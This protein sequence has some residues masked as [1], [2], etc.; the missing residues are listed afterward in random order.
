MGQCGEIFDLLFFHQKAES[1]TC[2][3]DKPFKHFLLFQLYFQGDIRDLKK[4]SSCSG[5]SLFN[6]AKRR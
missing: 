2:A 5:E 3:S 6:A 1:F 4:I